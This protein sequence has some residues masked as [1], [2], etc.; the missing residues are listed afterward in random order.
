MGYMVKGNLRACLYLDLYES[1]EHV[2]VK[3]YK[4][5]SGSK[6]TH[7]YKNELHILS[8]DVILNKSKNLLGSGFTDSEGNYVVDVCDSYNEGAIEIDLVVKDK[9]ARKKKKQDPIHFTVKRLMPVWRSNDE[10]KEFSWNYSFGFQLWSQVRHHFD[11]WTIIGSI[12]STE[13][14]KTPVEGVVVSAMDVDWVK[15][16]LLG[17]ATTDR[18]GK[19]RIDYTSIDYMQTFLSPLISIET[20]ISSMPGPGVYF[21]ITTSDGILLYEEKRAVG[22]TEERKNIPRC[23]NIDLYI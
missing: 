12:K 17:S 13:D 11:I 18:T 8:A 21:K 2:E 14:R 23:F 1:L 22:R 9:Q 7:D 16:D 5:N 15:D 4:V 10:L 20:P 19:F 3:I 6:V